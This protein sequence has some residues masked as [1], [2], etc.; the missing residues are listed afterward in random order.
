MVVDGSFGPSR[1]A[2]PYGLD[3]PPGMMPPSEHLCIAQSDRLKDCFLG[4]LRRI[5]LL[6]AR[7]NKGKKRAHCTGRPL[8]VWVERSAATP[9]WSL[10]QA[11]STGSSKIRSHALMSRV[12]PWSVQRTIT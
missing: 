7:V 2:Y 1:P 3:I 11:P 5:S 10:P 8:D 4:E 6:R 12:G 9:K